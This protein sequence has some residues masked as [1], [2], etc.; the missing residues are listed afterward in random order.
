MSSANSKRNFVKQFVSMLELVTFGAHVT[1]L[2]RWLLCIVPCV[3]YGTAE[4][5]D[6]AASEFGLHQCLALA[7]TVCALLHLYMHGMFANL[8]LPGSSLVV[9]VVVLAVVVQPLTITMH[10]LPQSSRTCLMVVRVRR[11]LTIQMRTSSVW[12]S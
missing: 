5:I 10:A 3:F 12:L 9:L 11:T 6:A 4:E 1:P 2:L 7:V 8:R